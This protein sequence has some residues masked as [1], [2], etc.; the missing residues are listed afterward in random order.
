MYKVR[1]AI[2]LAA[3]KGTRLRPITEKIPKPLIKVNDKVIIENIIET[4]IENEINEIYIV[5]GYLKEKFYYLNKKYNNITIV[6]NPL[7]NESNNISSLYVIRDYL[8][9]AII[10]DGDQIINNKDV[11]NPYFEKSAYNCTWTT[12]KTKEWLLTVKD[13]TIKKCCK[14][15]GENGW[16]LYS[17][18]RWTPKDGKQLKKDLET[19]YKKE[20]N[21]D[22]YWDEVALFKKFQYYDLGIIKKNENDIIEID[23]LDEL[24]NIDSSYSKIIT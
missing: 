16:Q 11:L 12:K 5:V 9:E 2:I 4:L 22:I 6:E 13:N 17:I 24:I 7:Y 3:G 15:G 19:V 23:T 14:T 21:K 10:M 18:S 1:R 20:H 8:E